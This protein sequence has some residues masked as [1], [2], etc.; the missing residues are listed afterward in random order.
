MAFRITPHTMSVIDWSNPGVEAKEEDGAELLANTQASTFVNYVHESMR[1]KKI[2]E[3]VQSL[4]LSSNR[5]GVGVKTAFLYLISI[6][7]RSHHQ[8]C[9]M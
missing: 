3:P 8:G 1:R 4:K 2:N 9:N 6:C 7:A 5:P